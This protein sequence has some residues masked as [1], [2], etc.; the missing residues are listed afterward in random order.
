LPAL[1]ISNILGQTNEW[2]VREALLKLP[3]GLFENLD[4]A[5]ERIRRQDPHSQA[6]SKLAM[7]TLMWLSH[8]RRP[9]TVDELKH[10]IGTKPLMTRLDPSNLTNAATFVEC[11]LGLV[12]IDE[13]TSIV[14]LVHMSVNEYLQKRRESFFP[15]AHGT[16]AVQ[17]LA[18]LSLAQFENC[19]PDKREELDTLSSQSPFLEYSAIHWGEHAAM[20]FNLEVEQSTRR[21]LAQGARLQLWGQLIE[22]KKLWR[23]DWKYDENDASQYAVRD[24]STLHIA[25]RFGIGKLA[26]DIL[27]ESGSDPN[28]R[29][30]WDRTPLMLAA[31]HGDKS[32][33]GALLSRDDID[34][35]MVDF[36]GRTA[37]G[38]AVHFARTEN[39]QLLLSCSRVDPNLGNVLL[40]AC[41]RYFVSSLE[42]YPS[43]SIELGYEITETLLSHPNFDVKAFDSK[44][45]SRWVGESHWEML[46][47]YFKFKPLQ[48]LLARKDLDPC[49]RE[50]P[51][52]NTDMHALQ[53]RVQYV[54]DYIF[55][56]DH[57]FEEELVNVVLILR[58]LEEDP[59]FPMPDY[60][61][62]RGT[63][64]VLY[65]VFSWTP[66][67]QQKRDFNG[68]SIWGQSRE[69][70][71]KV[72]AGLELHGFTLTIKDSLGRTFL[73]YAANECK[74]EH[75][76]FLLGQGLDAAAA[77]DL[78]WTPL[79]WAAEK[80]VESIVRMLLD[81]GA[82][83]SAKDRKGRT[84]LG[85][86]AEA[87][88]K[89][90]LTLLAAGADASA[91]DEKGWTP[92]HCA[93]NKGNWLIVKILLDNGANAAA[94]DKDG[95][96]PLH[97]AACLKSDAAVYIAEALVEH[98]AQVR[99][100]NRLGRTPLHLAAGE[101]TV[102][103][104]RFLLAEGADANAVCQIGTPL[105]EAAIAMDEHK[106]RT[107][108][109][110]AGDLNKLDLYGQ[111]SGDCIASFMPLAR[112]LGSYMILW[113]PTPPAEA[114][115]HL[116]CSLRERIE[117]VLT[118]DEEDC[119]QYCF[120]LGK[121]LLYLGDEIS[122]RIAF[123]FFF[124]H[125]KNKPHRTRW[126]MPCDNCDSDAG[127]QFVCK[128]CPTS[129][130]CAKCVKQHAGDAFPWCRRH[131]FLEVPSDGWMNLPEGVVN[132][133]GQSFEEWLKDLKRKYCSTEHVKGILVASGPGWPPNKR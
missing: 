25:A 118:A 108:L 107:I 13:E 103:M 113:N 77:D 47:K 109:L 48:H 70:R 92:L 116:L 67:G 9:L 35:N 16:L 122:A 85:C 20:C 75:V 110:Q 124:G 7:N 71:D 95:W 62:L 28:P 80:G 27:G 83:A 90:V 66:L 44:G 114:R 82:F 6:R 18:Y 73:H 133:E 30:S 121:Q 61:M 125:T 15:C 72:L 123:G 14:R 53:S 56:S 79:H 89:V 5:M 99:P 100:G 86:A 40:Q 17:C 111:S 101:G 127:V 32:F 93:A 120:R 51:H 42:S 58:L 76:R 41:E 1:Q 63:W 26:Q 119:D 54:C 115:Q 91:A 78:G 87:E 10:A 57:V 29:D 112:K 31:A 43:Q 52:A 19:L 68:F 3:T 81:S 129:A 36:E 60:Y 84:P 117:L 23:P 21:F 105:N 37:L 8:V 24:I 11:C 65:Y 96:T 4:L 128:S 102:E 132:E 97:Y 94:L 2:E 33:L 22:A 88:E 49:L 55:N 50:D 74:D 59:R 38:A 39:V 131:E 69:Y 34:V 46:A 12:T 106:I 126:Y 45:E 104:C 98:G 64:P 130:F